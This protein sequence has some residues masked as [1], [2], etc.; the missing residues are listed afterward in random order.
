[1]ADN[2]IQ[3]R[4]AAILAADVVGYS[5]MMEQ[6]EAGTLA[7]LKS[8][9]TEV[10]EPLV[11]RHQ[12]R[13]FKST[14]DGVLAEFGSAVNAVQCAVD[15]Q[16]RLAA[17]NSTLPDENPIVLRIGVNLGDVMVEGNDLFGDGVNIAARLEGL[18][19]PGRILISG[20][21][22]D[23]VRNK[24]K[25]AFEDLGSQTVKN[26]AE[27]VRTYRVQ[28]GQGSEMT[29]SGDKRALRTTGMGS[30]TLVALTLIAIGGLIWWFSPLLHAMRE[31]P[32]VSTE[33]RPSVAVLPFSNLSGDQKQDYFSDGL[34]EDILTALAR[35]P[36]LIVIARQS[37]FTFK[38]KSVGIAEI[39][40]SL[41]ARYV[42]EGSV[43]KSGDRVRVTAQLI[44]AANGSHL[45]AERFDRPLTD[46]FAVQDEIAEK[47][48]AILV[49]SV[50]RK[51]LEETRRK[52]PQN[53]GAY[54]LYLQG[55]ELFKSR[56]R[57]DDIQAGVLLERALALDP[58][59]APAYAELASVQS[60]LISLA[61]PSER[62]FREERLAKGFTLARRA[63]SLDPTLPAAHR[64]I[65]QL[66]SLKH[67]YQ[68][69]EA[70]ARKAIELNP[71]DAENYAALSNI[72]SRAGRSAEAVEMMHREFALDPFHRPLYDMFM[73]RAYVYSGEYAKGIPYLRTCIDREPEF[74]TCP[75]YLA[76]A[77]A[78]LGN[79]EEARKALTLRQR[80]RPLASVRDYRAESETMEGPE[81]NRLL[82]GLRMAG[83]PE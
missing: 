45:W 24:V 65:A 72:L 82:D 43:Q 56:L 47:I 71:G 52:A 53:V 1:M 10:I 16:E 6:D 4:L 3:R 11:T 42:L 25:V 31:V 77:E 36:E 54:D 48:V 62:E 70:S 73:G 8:R 63:L 30:V 76:A 51:S 19:E 74:R 29:R 20:T 34:S 58:N 21:A 64:V 81:L 59:F 17:A 61:I 26:M 28:L 7:K 44:E 18:A 67:D 55:R 78:Q 23:H 69:A 41:G 14:G 39:G 2:P 75:T 60:G 80:I 12:G 22:Y 27:P 32:I 66:Y 57:S 68:Q 9:L 38:G 40:R 13:V 37:S 49:A 5:R 79:L 83:L 35:F 33:P 50:E 15:I 46:M